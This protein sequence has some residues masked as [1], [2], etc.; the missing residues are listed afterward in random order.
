MGRMNT[1][2]LPMTLFSTLG[3]AAITG[4]IN[5]RS[6]VFGTHRS[7]S[8]PPHPF[9]LENDEIMISLKSFAEHS[10]SGITVFFSPNPALTSTFRSYTL[11][12]TFFAS[13]LLRQTNFT[14]QLLCFVELFLSYGAK[15]AFCSDVPPWSR[16][17]EDVPSWSRSLTE[18][19]AS[20]ALLHDPLAPCLTPNGSLLVRLCM[21]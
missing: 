16:S 8:N 2:P 5:S 21:H 11:Q 15:F 9:N 1:R 4:E 17:L 12:G 13:V 18:Q 3:D 19:R 10:M 6:L 7:S 14:V 20:T